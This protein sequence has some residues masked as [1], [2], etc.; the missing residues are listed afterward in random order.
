MCLFDS[1]L[2]EES[3]PTD[4]LK[5][6]TS[7]S[8]FNNIAFMIN[9]WTGAPRFNYFHLP[10]MNP[11]QESC[12]LKEYNPPGELLCLETC[13]KSDLLRLKKLVHVGDWHRH[14]WV[15]SK[16]KLHLDRGYVIIIIY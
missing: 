6:P 16:A 3:L 14:Q 12:H 11:P 7:V 8:A 10:V 4:V 2:S 1:L 15:I 13:W 5:F 9:I